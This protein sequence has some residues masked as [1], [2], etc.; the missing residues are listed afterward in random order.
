MEGQIQS[1]T[2][3]TGLMWGDHRADD[4]S[5]WELHNTML[6]R[7]L[8]LPSSPTTPACPM[9]FLAR[10]NILTHP[11]LPRPVALAAQA[12]PGSTGLFSSDFMCNQYTKLYTLRIVDNQRS[13]LVNKPRTMEKRTGSPSPMP[14]GFSVRP[15]HRTARTCPGFVS[16]HC[17]SL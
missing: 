9:S 4:S 13:V 7:T 1:S 11:A 6:M 10:G 17:L 12:Q 3:C 5:S 8:N 16:G 14:H 15:E 2:R